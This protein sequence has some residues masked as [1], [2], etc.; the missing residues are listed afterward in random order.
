[1]YVIK[2]KEKVERQAYP[3]GTSRPS[4][5]SFAWQKISRH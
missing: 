3:T 5:A 1:M 4:K 2:N